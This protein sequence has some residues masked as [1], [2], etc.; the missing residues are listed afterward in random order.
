MEFDLILINILATTLIELAETI[1]KITKPNG[2]VILSGFLGYQLQ[3]VQE[4]YAR[5]G[6]ALTNVSYKNAWVIMTLQRQGC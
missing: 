1:Y 6:F 4:A 3:S 5:I 2:Y